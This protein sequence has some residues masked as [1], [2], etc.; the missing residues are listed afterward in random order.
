M[1]TSRRWTLKVFLI[2]MM[3]LCATTL[4]YA[5]GIPGVTGTNFN[6]TAKADYI[7]T[8]DG[9]SILMWGICTE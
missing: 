6:F 2:L 1:N 9:N 8:P 5:H 7:S 4:L 3:L